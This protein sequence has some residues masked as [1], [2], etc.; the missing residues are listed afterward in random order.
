MPPVCYSVRD[1]PAAR[2]DVK[3]P[4]FLQQ[5]IAIASNDNHLTVVEQSVEHYCR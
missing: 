5:A 2:T 3:S 1:V 4:S